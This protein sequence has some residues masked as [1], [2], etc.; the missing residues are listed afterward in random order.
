VL[1][2]EASGVSAGFLSYTFHFPQNRLHS[3]GG[4]VTFW[5][6]PD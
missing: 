2:G 6:G 4:R 1:E 5:S 3:G